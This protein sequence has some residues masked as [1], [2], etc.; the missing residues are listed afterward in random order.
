[1]CKAK[2]S[3]RFGDCT[4]IVMVFCRRVDSIERAQRSIVL[5]LSLGNQPDMK[6]RLANA[7]LIMGRFAQHERVLKIR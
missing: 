6:K 1:M 5:P 7:A 4:L 2:M 3:C